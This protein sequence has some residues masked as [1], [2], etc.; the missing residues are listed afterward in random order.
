MLDATQQRL[1]FMDSELPSFLQSGAWEPVH[2]RIW[3]SIMF[4]VPKPGEIRWRLIVDL[5]PMN[6][7]SNE[8]KLTYETLKHLKNLTRTGD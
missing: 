3:I 6:K 2:R 4:L 1:D 8:H 7:Y 5:H